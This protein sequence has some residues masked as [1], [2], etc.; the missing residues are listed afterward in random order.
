[1]VTLGVKVNKGD[2]INK[3]ACGDAWV[4]FLYGK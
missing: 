1:M 4:S 3:L 2:F